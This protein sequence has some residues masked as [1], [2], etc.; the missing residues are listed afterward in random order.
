[1]L[2]LR[3]NAIRF[4][5]NG[6]NRKQV[7]P[8]NDSTMMLHTMMFRPTIRQQQLILPAQ[9]QNVECGLFCP[10]G[11]D[12]LFL[13]VTSIGQSSTRLA[14]SPAFAARHQTEHQITEIH[15]LGNDE[16]RVPIHMRESTHLHTHTALRWRRHSLNYTTVKGVR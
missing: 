10:M 13:L 9:L 16:S 8:K 6:T 1:M 7:T 12:G 15:Q 2:S 5:C 3:S 14:C 4:V 11:W